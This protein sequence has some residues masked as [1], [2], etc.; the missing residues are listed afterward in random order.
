[1]AIV[2]RRHASRNHVVEG[3]TSRP[4]NERTHAVAS[5]KPL[6]VMLVAGEDYVAAVRGEGIP[7][8]VDR[9]RIAVNGCIGEAGLVPVGERAVV[10]VRA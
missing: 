8:R 9:N 4:N 5:R 3:R 1:M 7:E 10:R 2:V 6:V